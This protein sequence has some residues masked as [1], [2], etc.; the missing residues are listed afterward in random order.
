MKKNILTVIILAATLVNLTLCGVMLFVYLPN[1]QKMNEMITKICQVIDLELESPLPVEKEVEIPVTDLEP[2]SVA[3]NMT[4]PLAKG[5]DGKVH[6]LSLTASIVLNTKAED[7]KTVQPLISTQAARIKEIIQD[8]ISNL[9]YENHKESKDLVKEEI[10]SLLQKEFDTE[11]IYR[12]DFA[13]YTA[14]N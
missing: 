10:L 13:V 11:C 6:Y 9:T 14:G 12:L 1:A 5:S 7:Y 8:S 4:I 2:I 3:D